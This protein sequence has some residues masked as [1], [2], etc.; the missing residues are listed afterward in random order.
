MTTLQKNFP[1]G[2]NLPQRDAASKEQ[3]RKDRVKGVIIV[4][5]LVALMA[6]MIWLASLG[7]GT[8]GGMEEFWP[9]M[10]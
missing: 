3:L 6:L 5:I 7:T 1:T 9:M 4:A 8:T 2:I 10:P